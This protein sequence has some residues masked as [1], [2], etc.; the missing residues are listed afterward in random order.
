M[1]N[2]HFKTCTCLLGILLMLFSG[3]QARGASLEVQQERKISGT[4]VDEKGEPVIGASV[5]VIETKQGTITNIDGKFQV[6]TPQNESNLQSRCFHAVAGKSIQ[7]VCFQY[8][9]GRSEQYGKYPDSW[10]IFA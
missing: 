3:I 1:R 2:I 4:V 5:V 9:F 8:G 7:C 10:Y 6:N